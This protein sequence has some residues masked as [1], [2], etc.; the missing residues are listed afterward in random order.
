MPLP[1]QFEGQ[2]IER[3]IAVRGTTWFDEEVETSVLERARTAAAKLLNAPKTQIAITSSA[4]EALAQ[5]AW[6]I[7]PPSGSNIVSADIEFPSVTYP[8]FRVAAETGAEVRLARHRT[9]PASFSIGSIASLVDERT[10]VIAVSHVQYSTGYRFA[11]EELSDLARSHDAKL[12]IDA[13]QSAGQVHLD[14]AAPGVDV[15]ALVAGGYKWLCGPFGAGICYLSDALL[16]GFQPAFVGWRS[17]PEPYSMDAG[18][19]RLAAD[20]RRLEFSTMSYGAAVALG[21]AIEYVLEFDLQEILRHNIQLARSL[22]QGLEALGAALITPREES[23]RAGIVTVRFPN[24]SGHA[25]AERLNAAGVIVSPR[26]GLTRFSLHFFNNSADV[27]RALEVL[28]GVPAPARAG[29]RRREGGWAAARAS[30]SVRPEA[31]Q[32]S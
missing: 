18:R 2:R 24:H 30:G 3:E 15:A 26:A 21:A 9:D 29:D 16:E 8:W 31:S 23:T 11:L 7:R 14:L 10:E 17:A 1:V 25:V 27:E 12:V 28:Q 32:P 6:A 4:T 22:E 20:A 13:T 5:V 19:L